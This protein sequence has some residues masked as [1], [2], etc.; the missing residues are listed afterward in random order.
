M[1]TIVL[2]RPN[3]Q[4]PFF[5]YTT[6]EINLMTKK[7][8]NLIFLDVDESHLWPILGRFNVTKRAINRAKKF[9]YPLRGLEYWLYLESQISAIVNDPNL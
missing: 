3:I 8:I 9:P 5:G 7:K 2:N 6:E 4:K 1:E